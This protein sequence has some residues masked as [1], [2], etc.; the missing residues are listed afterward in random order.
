MILMYGF[1]LI[2]IG[3]VIS[4]LSEGANG[5]HIPYRDSKLTRLLQDSLGGNTK[6]MMI[7]AISPADYNLEET[8]ST[9]RYASRAKN[10][11]NKPKINEDPKDAMI[12]EFKE[13][14][15]KLRS[16]L[17]QQSSGMNMNDNNYNNITASNSNPSHTQQQEE[18]LYKSYQDNST[19]NKSSPL[20]T[21]TTTQ[22]NNNSLSITNNDELHHN[23]SHMIE[24]SSPNPYSPD[25]DHYQY[26][27]KETSSN[28]NNNTNLQQ[29]QQSGKER[30]DAENRLHQLEHLVRVIYIYKYLY[31]I[32]IYK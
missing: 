31:N 11:K 19:Y 6:T 16:M 27:A 4:A 10:I 32:L 17:A 25:R 9:L 8:M 15:A 3:N 7:A 29:Q 12:R 18:S 1:D 26:S 24:D 20:K 14:I 30:L 13:E 28:S 2:Y 5:R 22:S 21:V 23:N